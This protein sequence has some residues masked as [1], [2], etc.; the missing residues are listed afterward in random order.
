MSDLEQAKFN[1]IEQQIRP[2]EVNNPQVI[3]ALHQI[4]RHEFVPDGFQGLA[5][6]DCNIPFANSQIMMK[7]LL[8]GKMLQAL[9]IN[10]SEICLEVGTGTGYLTACLASLAKTVHSIDINY[11]SQSQAQQKLSDQFQ[12]ITFECND[13]FKLKLAPL[14][15]DAI[16][17]TAALKEVADQF[18]NALTVGGRLFVIEGEIPTMQAIMITRTSATDWATKSLFETEMNQL[19]N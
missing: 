13:I 14:K 12:N 19:I 16:V 3:E 9:N 2:C 7:P 18:K 4:N 8:E 6:A 17:F 15:Y 1:M 11:D 5:Y 10:K